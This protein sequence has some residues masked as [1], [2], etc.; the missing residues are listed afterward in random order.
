[1]N[2]T[3]AWQTRPSLVPVA[4]S[5]TSS[6]LSLTLFLN[7]HLSLLFYCFLA[8]DARLFFTRHSRIGEDD[9]I[10][11]ATSVCDADTVEGEWIPMLDLVQH[12]G[13]GSPV[14]SSRL[15]Q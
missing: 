6:V 14:S 4:F 3:N 7:I 12:G 13:Q 9:L 1:M 11:L 5:T 15:K 10:E 8:S 2:Y